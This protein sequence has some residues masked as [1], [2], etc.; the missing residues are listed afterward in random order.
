[1]R[2]GRHLAINPFTWGTISKLT[3]ESGSHFEINPCT[4][5][6]V[7]SSF[8]TNPFIGVSDTRLY[9]HMD[10]HTRLI[11]RLRNP[12]TGSDS[13]PGDIDSRGRTATSD[14]DRPCRAGRSSS[15][16]HSA[17]SYWRNRDAWTAR[18]VCLCT[19]RQSTAF[20]ADHRQLERQAIVC[21]LDG[22]KDWPDD[23]KLGW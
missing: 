10:L 18:T 22:W 11:R 20:P 21:Q 7:G 4:T 3:R 17:G 1:M 9:N 19:R 14:F 15:S 5:L 6:H 12:D 16:R 8:E 2:L 23:M 13:N